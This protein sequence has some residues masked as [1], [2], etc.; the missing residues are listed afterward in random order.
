MTCYNT[1]G[2][3]ECHCKSGLSGSSNSVC[4]D[5]NE[6]LDGTAQCDINAQCFNYVGGWNC[7][8]NRG[9]E[10]NGF[11]CINMNECLDSNGEFNTCG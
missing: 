6:C 11:E 9:Y 4:S 10:G 1:D 3:Y 5:I 2:S 8:C 7:I